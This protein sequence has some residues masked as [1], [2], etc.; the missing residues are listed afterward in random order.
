MSDRIELG[1]EV[2][3]TISNWKGIVTAAH[4]YLHGCVRFNVCDRKKSEEKTFD[5]PQL[6]IIK[7]QVVKAPTNTQRKVATKRKSPPGGPEKHIDM[8]R[9]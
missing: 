6:V 9:L 7:K 1:D 3:D 5:E 8:N 2:K 4:V